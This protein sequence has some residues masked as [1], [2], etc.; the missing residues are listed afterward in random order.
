MTE[1]NN[2]NVP[3]VGDVVAVHLVSGITVLGRLQKSDD[4]G[5]VPVAKPMALIVQPNG[6]GSLAISMMPYLSSGVFPALDSIEFDLRHVMFLRVVPEK[7]EKLYMEMTSGI[8][9]VR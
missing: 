6:Q 7:I 4:A 2:H 9:L 1:I 8:A 5:Y 3:K